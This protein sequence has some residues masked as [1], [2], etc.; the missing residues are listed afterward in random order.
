MVKASFRMR[1]IVKYK[2][3][4]TDL[5]KEAN[6]YQDKIEAAEEAYELDKKKFEETM[7]NY[8]KEEFDMHQRITMLEKKVEEIEKKIK[9]CRADL[10]ELTPK[11]KEEKCVLQK[12]ELDKDG[13]YMA[14]LRDL[15]AMKVKVEQTKAKVTREQRASSVGTKK[16]ETERDQKK[17]EYEHRRVKAAK[18]VT[19]AQTP[20]LTKLAKE[21]KEIMKRIKKVQEEQGVVYE[22]VMKESNRIPTLKAKTKKLTAEFY[23]K[24]NSWI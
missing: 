7:N 20:T 8:C 13:A 18:E 19:R 21:E 4:L 22:L 16:Q 3:K 5:K 9:D 10:Y 1:Q 23:D 6:S 15:E 24:A 12:K 11:H 17:K 2:Q 14:A